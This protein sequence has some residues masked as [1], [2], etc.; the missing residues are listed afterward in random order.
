MERGD[1]TLKLKK[2]SKLVMIGDSIT[3]CGRKLPIGEGRSDGFGEGYV[4]LVNAF[5]T[6]SYPDYQIRVVNMGISGQTVR[7]LKNRWQSDLLDLHPD[8][9]SILIGINDVWR[10]FDQPVMPE[11]H[12]LLDEYEQTLSVLVPQ[13]LQHVQGV[14]LMAPFYL[15]PNRQD[16]MRAMMD[17][18]GAVVRSIAESHDCLFVDT[19]AVFDKLLQH[20]YPAT[21]ALDRV[22][23]SRSGHMTIARAFLDAI[24]FDYTRLL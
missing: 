18:Y 22:H 9:V 20:L 12:V 15:E 23:P 19:Q 21:I 8:W 17:D 13:T 11:S 7:D 5:L 3:D 16:K 2:G 1:I 6:S 10:Q 4:S 24:E 14:I